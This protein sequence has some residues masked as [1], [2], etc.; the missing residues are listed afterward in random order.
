GAATGAFPIPPLFN[1]V[2]IKLPAKLRSDIVYELNVSNV[3]DCAGNAIGIM[4]TAKTGLPLIADSLDIVINEILFNPKTNGY[5]YVEF[6]N[7]GNKIID[8]TKLYVSNRN[9][10]GAFSDIKQLSSSSLLFFPGEYYV[11]SENSLW[12]NQNYLVKNP[13]KVIELSSLPSLPDD[14]GNIVLL[15]QP[16]NIV[17]ELEYDHK[18]HFALIDNEQGVALERIDYNKPTQ[19][20]GNW[21]S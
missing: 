2:Q 17:D 13:D 8:L 9:V 14:H 6:Y 15:N 5:D 1:E 3:T 11:I 7:S 19:D 12:L 20:A 10:T 21:T 16:G 18:W 4:N